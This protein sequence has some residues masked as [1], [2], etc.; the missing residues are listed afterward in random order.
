MTVKNTKV[1]KFISAF[2]I[3][4]MLAPAI[5]FSAP[6]TAQAALPVVDLPHTGVSFLN[7][8]FSG[9]TSGATV[10]SLA[11]ATKEF[12]QFLLQQLL[13]RLAKVVLARITQATI[14]WINSDFHGSPLFLE[15]PESFFKDIAKSEIRNLVDMIG[16]DSFRFP[17]GRQTAL[18]VINS[19]RSQ[20]D[21][22]AEYTLSKVINDPRLLVRYRNDFN[23]GGWNGFLINTQYPQNNY[24]GFQGII[25]QN[26]ASRLE[27]TLVAPAQKIQQ[28]LQYGMGFLS[29]QT[30]PSNPNYN[31]GINEFLRPS[32][33]F[34]SN[35]YYKANPP[36]PVAD[37][38]DMGKAYNEKYERAKS[39]ARGIWAMKNT[40]PDGL[41]NTTPGSVVGNQ[42]MDAMGSNLRQTELGAALGN[43]LSAILDALIGHFMDKGLNALANTVNPRSSDNNWSYEGKKLSDTASPGALNAPRGTLDIN[44]PQHSVSL[45]ALKPGSPATTIY[46]T[47][48]TITGG[49][50]PYGINKTPTDLKATQKN[51]LDPTVSDATKAMIAIAI[52]TRDVHGTI[53]T[54]Q[55][56]Q[57]GNGLIVIQDSSTPPKKTFINIAVNN[58]GDLVT[59]QKSVSINV[60]DAAPPINIS[61]GEGIYR[62]VNEPDRNIAIA[63][64]AGANLLVVGTGKG[65]TKVTIQDSP[66][67][68]AALKTVEVVINIGAPGDLILNKIGE[69]IRVERGKAIPV[70]IEGQGKPPYFVEVA[71]IEKAVAE[72][73]GSTITITGRAIGETVLIFTDDSK[74]IKM[75]T[76]KII[77]TTNDN[78]GSCTIL[79]RSNPIPDVTESYCVNQG[80]V[81]WR[82]NSILSAAPLGVCVVGWE[83]YRDKTK[84]NCDAQKGK[85]DQNDAPVGICV[86]NNGN[87]I[88]RMTEAE[89]NKDS[90]TK[91]WVPNEGP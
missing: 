63:E 17:F 22:N 55:P 77:V 46:D 4:S 51:I 2:L 1:Q 74:P 56:A 23:Y 78:F 34:D 72:V 31:N 9:I 81:N 33:K 65:E 70:N 79:G 82:L 13:M 44:I 58:V 28:T 14:N 66:S 26:L 20:L 57:K 75:I 24:L 3:V 43:S 61:G 91:K 53:L 76:T 80:G 83:I 48:R 30:C 27:G 18:N 68:G 7:K 71:D 64:L 45:L 90:G 11:I 41:V 67:S 86:H 50:A 47:S 32:F 12:A 62:I 5:L 40:C 84:A 88:D 52:I 21:I 69:S 35:A 38:L 8:V 16:Y 59:S 42:I 73:L 25:Q 87:S 36:D 39:N 49:I 54:I 6:K 85:W 60:N 29:P 37:E 89:C 19:Y 15:N 10:G